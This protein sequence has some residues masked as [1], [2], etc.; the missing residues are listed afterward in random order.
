MNIRTLADGGGTDVLHDGDGL[1]PRCRWD[2]DVCAEMP[3]YFQLVPAGDG[4]EVEALTFCPR[5]HALTLAHLL[6]VHLSR[7]PHPAGRHVRGWG[8]LGHTGVAAY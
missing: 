1:E 5:H 7:C 4:E 8:R 3:S 6:E 2:D